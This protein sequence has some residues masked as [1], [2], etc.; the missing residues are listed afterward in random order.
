MGGGKAFSF[1]IQSVRQGKV[2]EMAS[3]LLL[4]NGTR[5][6]Q[7]ELLTEIEDDSD[8]EIPENGLMMEDE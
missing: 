1:V 6:V 2:D 5:F 4:D 3:W 8:N 7:E